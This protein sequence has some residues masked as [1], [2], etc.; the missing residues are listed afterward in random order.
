MD[1]AAR[2]AAVNN[3]VRD[4]GAV[5]DSIEFVRQKRSGDRVSALARWTEAHTGQ[6]RRGSVD[7]V[8]TDDVWRARGGW[9]SNANYDSDHPVWR[10]WGGTSHSMSGW[11]SDPA[12]VRVRFRDPQGRVAE[13]T[14]ENGVAILIYDTAFDRDSLVEALDVDGNVLHTAALA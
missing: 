1:D 3:L 5:R 2:E 4:S 10:A 12:A 11:V 8:K 7:V 9:G 13:D 6:L 14:V